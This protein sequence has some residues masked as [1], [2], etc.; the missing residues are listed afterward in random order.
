M[1]LFDVTILMR[2]CQKKVLE[3][4]HADLVESKLRLIFGKDYEVQCHEI[5]WY[6]V[7]KRPL[8]CHSLMNPK[9]KLLC[10]YFILDNIL[11][12]FF[13]SDVSG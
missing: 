4:S 6:T 13:S 2:L 3:L 8:V 12:I 5:K 1:L 10:I 11:F 9:G 7:K